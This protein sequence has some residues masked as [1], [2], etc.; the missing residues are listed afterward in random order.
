MPSSFARLWPAYALIASALMLA[1]AHAFETFGHLP[2]CE[3]C[4]KQR[5]VYWAAMLIGLA[6]LVLRRRGGGPT[7]RD[8]AFDALLALT[9]LMGAGLASYHVGVEWKW[10]PGPAACTGEHRSLSASDM[11]ALL[12][13]AKVAI[14]RCDQAAWRLFGLSMAGWN[15]LVSLGLAG[16]SALAALS[17]RR[18]TP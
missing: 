1:A 8:A 9:F 15:A 7:W 2:P 11:T 12:R 18:R 17:I 6:G 5:D 13:G 14:V 4:L 16:L 10:W 3:L